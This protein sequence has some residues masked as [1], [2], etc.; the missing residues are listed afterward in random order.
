MAQLR[1]LILLACL[2]AKLIDRDTIKKGAHA[3]AP[4]FLL[5]LLTDQQL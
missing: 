5:V 1:S 2:T 3:W 4:L